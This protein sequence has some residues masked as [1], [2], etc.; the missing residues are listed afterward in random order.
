MKKKVKTKSDVELS[1]EPAKILAWLS[2]ARIGGP[3]GPLFSGRDFPLD[4]GPDQKEKLVAGAVIALNCRP[5]WTATS[6]LY[7]VSFFYQ[8]GI[9]DNE[10]KFF[11][12]CQTGRVLINGIPVNNP[13]LGYMPSKAK[14]LTD[15]EYSIFFDFAHVVYGARHYLVRPKR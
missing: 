5:V 7:I 14:E 11:R 8:S 15:M 4:P 13:E 2:N 12:A 3:E 6:E 10:K 1:G 9:V